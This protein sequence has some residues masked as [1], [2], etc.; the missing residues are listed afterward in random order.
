MEEGREK[1]KQKNMGDT[2]FVQ[3]SFFFLFFF[4]AE[5]RRTLLFETLH[6]TLV[7][8]KFDSMLDPERRGA[9][10]TEEKCFDCQGSG[11]WFIRGRCPKKGINV[12]TKSGFNRSSIYSRLKL[13]F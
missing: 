4:L 11:H 1:T 12:P 6:C 10:G 13:A 9:G 7:M 2:A 5:R 3:C 8:T